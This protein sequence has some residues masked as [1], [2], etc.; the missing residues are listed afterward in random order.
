MLA[1]LP[2]GVYLL[3]GGLA[4]SL[5]LLGLVCLALA[6]ALGRSE[7]DLARKRD[8]CVRLHGEAARR[9]LRLADERAR[10][11]DAEGDL[12]IARERVAGLLERLQSRP[13]AAEREPFVIH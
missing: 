7:G 1:S 13:H 8:E 11:S 3:T 12:E 6:R 9:E 4:V 10:R 2:V 5:A